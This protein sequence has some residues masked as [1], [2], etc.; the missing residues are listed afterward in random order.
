MIGKQA[1]TPDGREW[2]I[3]EE[4]IDGCY[5][6]VSNMTGERRVIARELLAVEVES[7][8]GCKVKQ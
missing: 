2:T 4:E 6:C 5:S 7:G 8:F 3:L 1:I